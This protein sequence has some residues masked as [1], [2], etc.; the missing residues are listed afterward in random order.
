MAHK[1]A[2]KAISLPHAKLMDV[3]PEDADFRGLRGQARYKILEQLCESADARLIDPRLPDAFHDLWCGRRYNYEAL[4]GRF[5][6]IASSV[7]LT[8]RGPLTRD[9]IDKIITPDLP[10]LVQERDYQTLALALLGIGQVL[11]EGHNHW[12]GRQCLDDAVSALNR[13]DILMRGNL[14]T[15][16]SVGDAYLMPGAVRRRMGGRT[17]IEGAQINYGRAIHLMGIDPGDIGL[18]VPDD[19][20]RATQGDQETIAVY[21]PWAL[22]GLGRLRVW[23]ADYQEGRGHGIHAAKD[24]ADQA[25]RCFEGSLR[26]MGLPGH[27]IWQDLNVDEVRPRLESEG[28]IRNVGVAYLTMAR[29]LMQEPDPDHPRAY[30]T[31]V[32]AEALDPSVHKAAEE[33]RNRIHAIDPNIETTVRICREE[34]PTRRPISDADAVAK[35]LERARSQVR[36]MEPPAPKPEPKNFGEVRGAYNAADVGKYMSGLS[37]G[38]AT[39]S[40]DDVRREA[41]E[42]ARD[43][44]CVRDNTSTAEDYIGGLYDALSGHWEEGT[45]VAPENL[46]RV[47]GGWVAPQAIAASKL[48]SG[49]VRENAQALATQ[50]ETFVTLQCDESLTPENP[51]TDGARILGEY[52]QIAGR[53]FSLTGDWY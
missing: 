13:S 21:G 43:L 29:A 7:S 9:T 52:R 38:Y 40:A 20:L 22:N 36:P 1:L 33:Y 16:C 5:W 32:A 19:N 2:H 18:I 11:I 30:A 10:A 3:Q 49:S 25:V 46:P 26:I 48:F 35:R 51:G 37:T 27:L 47:L 42:L 15:L 12:R 44:T 28:R 14:E 50:Y 4:E 8:S 45:A 6:E 23:Q 24:K 53:I 17:R 34:A 31:A 41:T 39:V